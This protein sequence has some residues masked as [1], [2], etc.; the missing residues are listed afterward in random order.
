MRAPFPCHPIPAVA[1][2]IEA[3]A[4]IAA[5]AAKLGLAD[6]VPAPLHDPYPMHSARLL[7]VAPGATVP[8]QMAPMYAPDAVAVLRAIVAEC[9]AVGSPSLGVLEDARAIIARADGRP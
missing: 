9:D 3:D 4:V 5:R 2:A 6:P 8:A 1:A 7:E